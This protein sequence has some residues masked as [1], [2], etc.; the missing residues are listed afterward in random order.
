ML[1]P[2]GHGAEEVVSATSK[3][4]FEAKRLVNQR[5]NDVGLGEEGCKRL[6]VRD[7]AVF[8]RDDVGLLDFQYEA[9]Q[10]NDMIHGMQIARPLELAGLSVLDSDEG[11][12]HRDTKMLEL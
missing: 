4:K 10:H 3:L 6:G 8:H 12:R 7:P 1:E 5:V 9:E 2:A 11:I